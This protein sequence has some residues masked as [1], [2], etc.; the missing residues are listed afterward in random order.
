MAET[1]S[2][3]SATANPGP[4]ENNSVDPQVLD[5]D[6]DDGL[7]VE[8]VEAETFD[9]GP[10]IELDQLDFNAVE[11]LEDELDTALEKFDAEEYDIWINIETNEDED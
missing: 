9:D 5:G 4:E 3:A 10:W 8:E 2:N 11:E 6:A 7:E 1:S